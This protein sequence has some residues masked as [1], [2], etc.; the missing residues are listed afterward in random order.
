MKIGA[1]FPL[2]ILVLVAGCGSSTAVV[3]KKKEGAFVRFLNVTDHDILVLLDGQSVADGPLK[4]GKASI[5]RKSLSGPRKVSLQT[6]SNKESLSPD[7]ES[8]SITTYLIQDQGGKSQLV[9]VTGEVRKNESGRSSLRLIYS[10]AK[11][12]PVTVE[13][14]GKSY[15]L[16][17]S[18]GTGAGN[19]QAVADGDAT[20]TVQG[21]SGPVT[22]KLEPNSSFCFLVY[23][24]KDGMKG[25]FVRNT[26]EPFDGSKLVPAGASSMPSG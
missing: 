16:G 7:L 9:A 24:T 6:A 5:F 18:S 10:D 12:G 22:A 20:A 11:T 1:L 13:I 25:V 17:S 21:L 2:S 3:K 26:P 14:G 15:D 8:A 4:P 19:Y 23:K